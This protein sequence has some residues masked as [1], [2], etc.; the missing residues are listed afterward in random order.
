M[1]ALGSI[2][3]ILQAWQFHFR[4]L[5]CKSNNV[6]FFTIKTTHL[7]DRIENICNRN[8]DVRHKSEVDFDEKYVSPHR[9]SF[10]CNWRVYC[11]NIRNSYKILTTM[12]VHVSLPTKSNEGRSSR[13]VRMCRPSSKRVTVC[14]S[15]RSQKHPPKII[16][17]LWSFQNDSY[18][19]QVSVS[20]LTWYFFY[21][22]SRC[23]PVPLY[24]FI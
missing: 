9:R 18:S 15:C 5:Y 17:L 23:A 7:S 8:R 3:Q 16:S 1:D 11:R 19:K 21:C 10:W 6:K 24:Y 14:R 12:D 2:L 20:I 22:Y 13:N 4:F